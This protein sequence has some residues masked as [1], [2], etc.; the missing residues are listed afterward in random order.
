MHSGEVKLSVSLCFFLFSR[1][2]DL[3]RRDEANDIYRRNKHCKACVHT[4]IQVAFA[5]TRA[6]APNL[7][8]SCASSREGSQT[9]ILKHIS[10]L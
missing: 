7:F 1:I 10:T 6:R 8:I 9:G 3:R 2:N 4:C 5:S